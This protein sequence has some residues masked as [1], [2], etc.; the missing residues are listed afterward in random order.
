[1][2][3]SRAA[4]RASWRIDAPTP[5]WRWTALVVCAGLAVAGCGGGEHATPATTTTVPAA[6]ACPTVDEKPS[7]A[8]SW[9]VSYCTAFAAPG[10]IVATQLVPAVTGEHAEPPTGDGWDWEALRAGCDA[11]AAA[12]PPLTAV[13]AEAPAS[14][15]ELAGTTDE[16][17]QL[18]TTFSTACGPATQRAD[19]EEMRGLV[20]LLDEAAQT[21]TQLEAMVRELPEPAASRGPE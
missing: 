19:Y 2:T 13:V 11:L 18:L 20:S 6:E 4:R 21:A 1:M 8:A 10:R 9:L 3:R 7:G 15:A 5:P 14:L 12:L 16:Y 17:V